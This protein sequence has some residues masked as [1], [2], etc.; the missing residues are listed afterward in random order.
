M[1][2]GELLEC[3]S[4]VLKNVLSLRNAKN[5]PDS[6]RDALK[7]AAMTH[8]RLSEKDACNFLLDLDKSGRYQ[9]ETWS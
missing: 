9:A 8:G 6:V 2:R 1:L 3:C 4:Y 5:M 7:K